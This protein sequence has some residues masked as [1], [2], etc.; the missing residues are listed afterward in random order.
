[1]TT[2]ES[3]APAANPAGT[4]QLI[5]CVPVQVHPPVE[6]ERLVTFR[7]VGTLSDTVTIC[8][9]GPAVA[10]FVSAS[11]NVPVPFSATVLL[12]GV[13]AKLSDGGT[14]TVAVALGGVGHD[15]GVPQPPLLA[16][17]V[18]V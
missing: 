11:V 17:R 6:D 18:F 15:A 10:L 2:T 5:V 16:V 12:A 13:L 8:V 7:F 1:L 14:V 9:V 3:V 4:L